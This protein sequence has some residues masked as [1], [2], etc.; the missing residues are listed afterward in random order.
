MIIDDLLAA[1]RDD[2]AFIIARYC[3][4]VGLP[5]ISDAAY[6]A[7]ENRIRENPTEL[8]KE[9]LNRTYDDDPVP[10]KLLELCKIEEVKLGASSELYKYLDEEKSNS[11]RAV[12]SYEEAFEF[13]QKYPGKEIMFSLKLDG[14][15]AK[16]LYKDCI[17]RL[18]LS[19]GR[20]SA[21]F[22]YTNGMRRIAPKRLGTEGIIKITG[23]CYVDGQYL[24]KLRGKYDADKYVTSKSSATSML[25][26]SHDL[27]DYVGL[28]LRAFSVEGTDFD[29]VSAMYEWLESQGFETPPH[30]LAIPDAHSFEEFST[31][32]RENVFDRMYEMRSELPSDGIVMEVN[33]LQGV[34]EEK[35]QYSERQ[36]ALKFEQWSFEQLRGII[37]DIIIGQQRVYKSVRIKIEQI[38]SSDGCKATYINSFNPRILIDNDLHVGSEVVFERNAGAVN[39]L[40]H[41]KRLKEIEESE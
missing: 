39:I 21:G 1:G 22:D 27:E 17:F 34:Y 24:D 33:D 25:R 6:D 20:A 15:N 41:G 19:R 18:S 28:H 30:F 3:Y 5:T 38:I 31:W 40:I 14:V 10:S 26:V 23:E 7:L 12:H 4:R 8:M 11:I 32:L 16:L 2:V 37:T 13:I 29:S 9:Y 36:I 35:N